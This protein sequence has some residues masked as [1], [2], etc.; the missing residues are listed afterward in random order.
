MKKR[1]LVPMFLTF[2]LLLM[3]LATSCSFLKPAPYQEVNYYTIGSAPKQVPITYNIEVKNFNSLL[4]EKN[5]M[6]Y[7][8]DNYHVLIDDYNKWIQPPEF[9]IRNYVMS[10][11]SSK[12]NKSCKTFVIKGVVDNFSINTNSKNADLVVRYSIFQKKRPL[13][14]V[15]SK[16]FQREV[17]FEKIQ[18]EYFAKS[19]AMLSDLLA[20]DIKN[21]IDDYLNEAIKN[22]IK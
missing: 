4:P 6:V 2:N 8:K 13:N 9:M 10:K 17:S 11:F 19:F 20:I 14:P 7:T 1:L 16:S 18:P 5:R 21:S 15:F 22:E 3:L 12:N